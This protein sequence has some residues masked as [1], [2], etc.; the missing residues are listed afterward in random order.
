MRDGA[1]AALGLGFA[2]TND[3]SVKLALDG[4]HVAQQRFE[5]FGLGGV[6]EEFEGAGFENGGFIAAGSLETPEAGGDFGDQL[7][8]ESAGGGVVREELFMKVIEVDL[9]FPGQDDLPA[10]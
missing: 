2:E 10:G 1:L 8:F 7:G 5:P 9:V 6:D 3:G 4:S